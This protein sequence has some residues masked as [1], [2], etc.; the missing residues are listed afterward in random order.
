MQGDSHRGTHATPR[1]RDAGT[2]AT[3]AQGHVGTHGTPIERDAGTSGSPTEER[4]D[5][6]GTPIEE[7]PHVGH[8]WEPSTGGWR[9]S[10]DPNRRRLPIRATRGTPGLGDADGAK[11]AH[12][13]RHAPF[14]RPRE[15][16]PPLLK[17]QRSP[18]VGPPNDQLPLQRDSPRFPIALLYEERTDTELGKGGGRGGWETFGPV[19]ALRAQNMAPLTLPLH[20][21]GGTRRGLALAGLR[22]R[23]NGAR[24]WRC[25]R[26]RFAM[27]SLALFP[28]PPP[29]GAVTLCEFNNALLC[30]RRGEPLPLDFQSLVRKHPLPPPSTADPRRGLRTPNPSPRGW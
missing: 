6:Y 24:G 11:P 8:P 3:P 13:Q 20:T 21:R 2:R 17:G 19:R 27:C 28:P 12:Q 22:R 23:L 10:W 1:R 4:T 26:C 5:P 25:R 29:P 15:D 9:C 30:G 7:S 14:S 16:A 18:A